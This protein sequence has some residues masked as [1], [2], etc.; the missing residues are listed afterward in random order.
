MKNLAR[1]RK[2]IQ[3]STAEAQKK[4]VIIQSLEDMVGNSR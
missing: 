3:T 4:I 2:A 1:R